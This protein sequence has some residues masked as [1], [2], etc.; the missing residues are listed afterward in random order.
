VEQVLLGAKHTPLLEAESWTCV[1][2]PEAIDVFLVNKFVEYVQL[3]L[4]ELFEGISDHVRLDVR[5]L[6][7]L[8]FLQDEL[9]ELWRAVS[10]TGRDCSRLSRITRLFMIV[11]QH[12]QVW[13]RLLQ[14][15]KLA[16]MDR[17]HQLIAELSLIFLCPLRLYLCLLPDDVE[18][19]LQLTGLAFG[20]R[21]VVLLMRR[22]AILHPPM[23][24]YLHLP[25]QHNKHSIQAHRYLL[26]PINLHH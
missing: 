3:R 7:H 20:Q 14:L 16:R 8:S 1:A 21:M 12:L 9:L 6:F 10:G 23:R 15:V 2:F 13:V 19:L 17:H 25:L 24:L 18:P 4:H 22:H 26:P 11:R 5:V